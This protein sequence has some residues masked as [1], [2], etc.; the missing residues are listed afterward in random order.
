MAQMSAVA[1]ETSLQLK[2]L[3]AAFPEVAPVMKQM[4][5]S[6]GGVAAALAGMYKRGI[7]A[8]EA[9][10]GLKFAL[11]RLV[12]PTKD[13]GELIKQ[14]GFSFFNASGDIKKA[15]FEIMALAKNLDQMTPE[16][17]SKALGELFGL[18]QTARMQ[19]FF[20]DVNIGRQEL[21][22]L[23][24]GAIS[25]SQMTSDYAR[26]LVASG[27][28]AGAAM[29]PMDRYNKALEEIKKDPTTGIKRLKA[30]FEDFKVGLG[31]AVAPALIRVGE[32]VMKILDLFN[33]LPNSMQILIVGAAVF[34]A[35]LAPIMIILAQ[36]THAF[37]TLGRVAMIALPKLASNFTPAVAMGSIGAGQ[38]TA[39][40][41]GSKTTA[42]MGLKD[43]FRYAIGM[44]TSAEKAVSAAGGAAKTGSLGPE[45]AATGALTAAKDNLTA[46]STRVAVAE[47]RET[48][49]HN[50]NAAAMNKGAMWDQRMAAGRGSWIDLNTKKTIGYTR[51]LELMTQQQKA[52]HFVAPLTPGYTPPVAKPMSNAAMQASMAS[53]AQAAAT[54][55]KQQQAFSNLVTTSQTLSAKKTATATSSAAMGFGSLTAGVG[56]QFKSL[57]TSAN[58][59]FFKPIGTAAAKTKKQ[60][61]DM[62]KAAKISAVGQGASSL[63]GGTMGAFGK[64]RK[65]ELAAGAAT[66][67]PLGKVGKTFGGLG[68]IF[69]VFTGKLN[70]VKGPLGTIISL[71]LKFNKITLI[72]TVVAGAIAFIVMM[73]KG[74]K[75]NWEAVMAKIQPGIDAIKDAFGR[76]KETFAGV[77]EKMMG[78]FGQLGTG[79]EEGKGA[80]SAFEGIGG[81]IGA[82]FNGI[83]SA[84]DFV[85]SVVVFLWPLFERTAYIVKNVVGFISAIFKGEWKQAFMF[86]LAVVY[87]WVRPVLVAFDIVVKGVAQALSSLLGLVSKIPFV[88]NSLKGA[89]KAVEAFS[90][91]GIVGMLDDKLR[92][93]LG[94]V[95]GPGTTGPAKTEAKKAGGEIGDTL[96]EAIN[97]GAGDAA[98][99]ES[100]V[101]KWTETVVSE[102]DKQL[103]KL[104]KSATDAL[105]KAHEAALKVYDERIK[106]IEDQE[107][108]E[109]RLFRTEEYLSNKRNL[110]SKRN[111]DRQNYENER[112]IALYEGRYND[113]RML[114]LKERS[115]KRDYSKDLTGI[116]DSRSKDLLKEVR[117]GLKEQINAEKD[118]AKARFDIQKQSFE[119]YLEELYKMTPVTVGQ[120]QSMMDQINGVL[121]QSGA[122]WPGYA[123]TAMDR[124]GKALSDA[125]KKIINE[126]NRTDNNPLLQ[127]VAAFAEPEVV[128]ILKEGLSKASGGGGSS[129]T[130]GPSED[131]RT[132]EEIEADFFASL[133]SKSSQA[134]PEELAAWVGDGQGLGG[135]AESGQTVATQGTPQ[136]V[137]RP[138]AVTAEQVAAVIRES[139]MTSESESMFGRKQ[140]SKEN[141]EKYGSVEQYASAVALLKQGVQPEE[142]LDTSKY[143][144]YTD[145][146][147]SYAKEVY[148]N[149]YKNISS[150]ATSTASKSTAEILKKY[151]GQISQQE[152]DST[153]LHMRI[154]YFKDDEG[155]QWREVNGKMVNNFGE[156]AEAIR[157]KDGEVTG[158]RIG[159]S[160]RILYATSK[161]LNTATDI[162]NYMT[163]NGIKPN[164]E[165]AKEFE[166]KLAEVGYKVDEVGGKRILIPMDIEVRRMQARINYM[167][168]QA[169]PA[170]G[171][172]PLDAIYAASHMA[173]GGVVKA[174]KDGIIANIG[175]GGFDEYVITTD[176]KYRASNLGFLSAA[177]S[178]L[179]VK[180][181][182][183][184][185]IKAASGG[186]FTRGTAGGSSAEY[187]SGMG[188]DVYIN[189]DTFIGEEE[190]FASMASKYNMKT[191]PR[192]RKIEGQQKR[193]VSS[194]NDRYRLR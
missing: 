88:G 64:G 97:D 100:W 157:S 3:A 187:A 46:A 173:T 164:T 63:M 135:P 24:R 106:A 166:R 58:N 85:G 23:E 105:E 126:F 83:A 182:S 179:G 13:S 40:Q 35:A 70:I 93:G 177:A 2:D 108:A 150:T 130:G 132:P 66:A 184:A 48:I 99:G 51:A 193:V 76:L 60:L 102:I 96:G 42:A 168:S 143:M 122:N 5:F 194:Y 158:V 117:D 80:A 95:F 114:D 15:D 110:L 178:R 115:D 165:A 156:T 44:R 129:V 53:Q 162:L 121:Q 81:I 152:S 27:K 142:L 104:K 86:A 29:K 170:T 36:M 65:G 176:P 28:V 171:Y 92:T 91:T 149:L 137:Y 144:G 160:N 98:D 68:Q 47:A 188:G 10:H 12:S 7:P 127:W 38:S 61:V 186:M 89:A 180:M 94:G 74:M 77:F 6:A 67:L 147:V 32:I 26:G 11:Q 120:F 183:G 55:K 17:A 79:A 109:E 116:E 59:T 43:R 82:V 19:S 161:E 138:V 145:K 134:T 169:D 21:E 159:N 34:V 125:N 37:V 14:M 146:I 49:A 136:S 31:A 153:R 124:M 39:V 52:A 50:A 75:T 167:K 41:A 191:V 118:A 33:K 45:T 84:I 133:R 101:K 8:T 190:W 72:L 78:I 185:A 154:K 163:E 54:A 71:F 175:E 139:G 90:D 57:G 4:G 30:A 18:R 111:I 131:T 1:D 123:E 69:G 73:F 128:R 56:A 62:A 189:V 155:K 141:I 9:A 119:D 103:E 87:E 172:I 140:G 151:S 20:Q 22:K 112:A 192:Q 181:A 25:A 16:K 148:K 174:Q 107:K 113:V